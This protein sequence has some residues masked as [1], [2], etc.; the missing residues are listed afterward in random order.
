MLPL[1]ISLAVAGTSLDADV[2]LKAGRSA[3]RRGEGNVAATELERCIAVG[4]ALKECRWL[5][6][7]AHWVEGRWRE[8]NGAWEALERDDP[9]FPGLAFHLAE[10]KAQ[11]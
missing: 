2:H 8:A 3:L 10:A 1:L 5:L 9:Q 6:G 7:W 11:L 4:P